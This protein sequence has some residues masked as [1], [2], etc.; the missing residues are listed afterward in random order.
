VLVFLLDRV[1]AMG[2]EVAEEGVLPAGEREEGDLLAH[3]RRIGRDLEDRRPDPRP[4]RR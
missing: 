2:V 1:G 3:D 4:A